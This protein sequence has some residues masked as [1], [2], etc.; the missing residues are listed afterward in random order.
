MTQYFITYNQQK[1]TYLVW[2]NQQ[3]ICRV[4]DINK[5][6]SNWLKVVEFL[7]LEYERT[8]QPLEIY[9]ILSVNADLEGIMKA[10]EGIRKK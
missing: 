4:S 5:D 1:H 10:V 2:N 8:K 6:N 9:P 7:Q 3:V